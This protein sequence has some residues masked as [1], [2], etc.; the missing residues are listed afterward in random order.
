MHYRNYR[1]Y[2]PKTPGYRITDSE[3]F[4]PVHCKT[5]A[6]EPRDTAR[7]ASQDLKKA[8]QEKNKLATFNLTA[9]HTET[10]CQLANLFEESAGINKEITTMPF[11][12]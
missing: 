4:F 12:R 8:L 3:K 1:F 6:I 9:R 11:R 5:P 2:I 10:I 7:L